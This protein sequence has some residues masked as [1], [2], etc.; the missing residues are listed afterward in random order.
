MVAD[1]LRRR[2]AA[3]LV[4]Q[5]GEFRAGLLLHEHGEHVILALRA[6]AAHLERRTRGLGG[7]DE[8]L[9]VLRAGGIVPQHELVERDHRHRRQVAPVER[10]FRRQ[11]QHVD[12][13]I[14][15]QHLVGVA[16]AGLHV[17]QRFGAGRPALQRHHHRLLHQIVLLDR[18]LHHARHL[19]GGA[20]GAG[21][22]HDFNRLGRLPGG[23]RRRTGEHGR[24][25]AAAF[26]KFPTCFFPMS[27]FWFDQN[28][29]CPLAP[30]CGVIGAKFKPNRSRAA[31]DFRMRLQVVSARDS[32]DSQRS[33]GVS[34]ECP[35]AIQTSG[36][37]IRNLFALPVRR[38]LVEE[39]IHALAE[40]LAHIGAQDQ[41]LALVARQRAA[42]AA[43]RFLGDFQRDRRM[44]G[45]ELRGFIGAALQRRDVGHHLV[46]QA[47]RQ[48]FRRFDQPRL[49]DQILGPRRPDQRD[50]PG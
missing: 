8:I 40:I 36:L 15:D 32:A 24:Q 5:I 2:L 47:E 41:V 26:T 45:N 1:Q 43:H 18:R 11:R 38:A 21:R 29:H 39:G 28:R 31:Y 27:L 42:D 22:D 10:N 46:E 23:K 44:A 16:F 35:P 30:L 13:R 19:V 3:G 49:E 6:G 25:A 4:G 7:R 17:H 9:H 34:R 14:G 48:R 20:A 50:Q 37:P 33:A 12:Q